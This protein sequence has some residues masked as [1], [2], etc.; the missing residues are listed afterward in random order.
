MV[1]R[2]PRWLARAPIPLFR[3]GLGR[4]LG[5][6]VVML[7]HRGRRTGQARYVVLEVVDRQPG[8]VR[9][10]SGYGTRSQWYRNVMADPHVKIWTGRL[11]GSPALATALPA[12]DTR[13]VLEDYRR[14]N[15]RAARA[16][17]RTLA[18]DDLARGGPLPDTVAERLPIV[19]LALSPQP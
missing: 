6:R 13:Q 3:H 5:P 16:L 4:L 17:G 1:R 8:H 2:I 18:I 19:D 12:A 15:A 14:R 11:A 9:V 7:E 10:V